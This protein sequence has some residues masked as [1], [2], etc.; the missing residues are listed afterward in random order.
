MSK[1]I[2]IKVEVAFTHQPRTAVG[3]IQVKERWFRWLQ[4][5]CLSHKMKIEK[6][7]VDFPSA[8][9]IYFFVKGGRLVVDEN[10]RSVALISKDE[11]IFL[12]EE[13]RKMVEVDIK[14]L[15]FY[16]L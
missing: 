14:D 2:R 6:V 7:E 12:N 1:K 16:G 5:I 8:E 3:I 15:I 11:L 9:L 10:G 4:L 13:E